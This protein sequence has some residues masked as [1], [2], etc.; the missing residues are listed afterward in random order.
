MGGQSKTCDRRLQPPLHTPHCPASS[1]TKRTPTP[2]PPTR[3]LPP[4]RHANKALAKMY[5]VIASS[6][7]ELEGHF[8]DVTPEWLREAMMEEAPNNVLPE[9][10]AGRRGGLTVQ[11]GGEAG[12][13]AALL[14]MCAD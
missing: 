12:G 10:G 11:G 4:G 8:T 13:C 7:A 1:L 3:A 14:G 2:P 6:G 5:R 9:S